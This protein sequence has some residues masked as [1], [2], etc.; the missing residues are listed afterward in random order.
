MYCVAFRTDDSIDEQILGISR[1][2]PQGYLI[3]G[4]QS[5]L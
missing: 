1:N 4:I 2:R 5:F 3:P